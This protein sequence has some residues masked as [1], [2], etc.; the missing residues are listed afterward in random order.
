MDN[1]KS[2]YKLNIYI[3]CFFNLLQII[4]LFIIMNIDLNK[5]KYYVLSIGDK[6]KEDHVK[7]CLNKSEIKFVNPILG[8]DKR[9]SGATGFSRIID[10]SIKEQKNKFKPFIILEDDISIFNWENNIIIPENSDL[11]YLGA[12]RAGMYKEKHC[13][14]VFTSEVENFPN[15]LRI[16]NMCSTHAILVCNIKGAM[17][18]QKCVTEDY[19]KKRGWDMS[20]AHMQPHYNVYALKKPIFYQD[21]EYGGQQYNTKIVLENIN[22][23]KLI[24]SQFFN[25]TNYSFITNVDVNNIN[26]KNVIC[27]NVKNDEKKISINDKKNLSINDKKQLSIFMVFLFFCS[28]HYIQIKMKQ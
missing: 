24:N 28:F 27:Q 14:N 17:L 15:L 12:S 10:L 13:Y 11:V 5:L 16:Y 18:I 20:L 1:T 7:E 8:I 23:I 2:L 6:N 22:D 19:Y 9:Q 3:Y 25:T 26:D 4:S 21:I